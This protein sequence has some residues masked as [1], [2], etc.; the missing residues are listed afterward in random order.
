M[1]RH[2]I[3]LIV[4][5]CL[6]YVGYTNFIS[7]KVVEAVPC[8]TN[9]PSGQ[10]HQDIFYAPGYPDLSLYS[11][12]NGIAKATKTLNYRLVTRSG[13]N[14]GTIPA[15]LSRMEQHGREKVNFNLVRVTDASYKF[16]VY[17]SCGTEHIS[18]CGGVNIYCLPD[19]FPINND[20]WLSD[21]LNTY[22]SGSQLAI[23]LHEIFGHAIAVWMEQY[24]LDGDTAFVCQGL[25]RFSPAPGW[26]DFM[27]TGPNSRQGFEQHTLDRWCRTM[28]CDGV[29]GQNPCQTIG[30][31]P[32]TA[33]WFFADGWSWSTIDYGWYN[34]LGEYEWEP[35]NADGLRYNRIL[36]IFKY[37]SYLTGVYSIP[38]RGFWSEAP[39]PC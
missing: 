7:T 35:C 3:V 17:I 29:E 25:P 38:E 28:Y 39:Y 4:G 8:T 36:K 27:N 32:C 15:M 12:I 6:G 10:P 34:P 22:D 21:Q 23:P 20:V 16:T 5:V 24:C 14:T 18:K 19:G 9:C 31:D 11:T 2:L 37:P 26:V 1:I 13:C 33:R 30:Y